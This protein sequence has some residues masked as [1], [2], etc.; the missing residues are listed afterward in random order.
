MIPAWNAASLLF[1]TSGKLYV[2]DVWAL[3]DATVQPLREF[4]R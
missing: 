2:Q 1:R 4:L 3:G